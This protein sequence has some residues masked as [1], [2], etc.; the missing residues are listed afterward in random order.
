MGG[1]TL[2]AYQNAKDAH[3]ACDQAMLDGNQVSVP[4]SLSSYGLGND[5]QDITTYTYDWKKYWE[6]IQTV[7]QD[8]NNLEAASDAKT[9]TDD[10]NARMFAI[11]GRQFTTAEKLKIPHVE[12]IGAIQPSH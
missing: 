9:T 3:D 5:Q 2:Q 12:K 4:S 1:D 8:P 7:L 10:A 11:V 6:D